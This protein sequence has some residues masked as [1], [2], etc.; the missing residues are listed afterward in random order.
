MMKPLH[1]SHRQ[2][3]RVVLPGRPIG[4]TFKGRRGDEVRHLETLREHASLLPS[5]RPCWLRCVLCPSHRRRARLS[6]VWLMT[7]A[8]NGGTMAPVGRLQSIRHAAYVGVPL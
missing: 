3:L 5:S 2:G 6:A 8:T 1:V 4:R 7:L